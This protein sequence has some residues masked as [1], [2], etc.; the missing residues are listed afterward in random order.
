M[1]KPNRSEPNALT[2][3][4]GPNAFY[5]VL[6]NKPSPLLSLV[7]FSRE[8][9]RQRRISASPIPVTVFGV[10]TSNTAR[11]SVPETKF[12]CVLLKFNKFPTIECVGMTC[13]GECDESTPNV[14]AHPSVVN[15]EMSVPWFDDAAAETTADSKREQWIA[16]AKDA[17]AKTDI[18]SSL[19]D[20]IK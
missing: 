9:Q 19:P 4:R 15:V 7:V 5:D 6:L 20:S 14:Y 17:I 10:I 13:H 2:V 1:R 18:T 12:R 3:R 11:P 8:S 16:I